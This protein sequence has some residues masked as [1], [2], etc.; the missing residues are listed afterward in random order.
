VK[1][2]ELTPR[3]QL[4]YGLSIAKA[5][6]YLHTHQPQI[7]HRDLTS[8]NIL[9]NERESFS[10]FLCVY[11]YMFDFEVF[12]LQNPFSLFNLT[13]NLTNKQ[14]IVEKWSSENY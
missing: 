14:C 4:E 9:V 8:K 12:S 7:V 13:L 10:F 5:M 1:R 6:E 2:K 3:E 11:V